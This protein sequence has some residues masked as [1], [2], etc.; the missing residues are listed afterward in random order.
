M[1][2]S[3][4]IP[5]IDIPIGSWNCCPTLVDSVKSVLA[6]GHENV[7]V[8]IGC[9]G[10]ADD[11]RLDP[12]LHSDQRIY[13]HYFKRTLSYGNH[14]RHELQKI[15]TGDL[16]VFLD[17]DD[18]LAEGS[19]KMVAE[20]G[21]DFPGRVLVYSSMV[22]GAYMKPMSW[23]ENQSILEWV[24]YDEYGMLINDE[25]LDRRRPENTPRV[26]S[27]VCH[28]RT[29]EW[30]DTLQRHADVLWIDSVLMKAKSSEK[31]PIYSPAVLG[32]A[33]PLH[34]DVHPWWMGHPASEKALKITVIL[35]VVDVPIGS[36][37]PCHWLKNCIQ[38]VLDGGHEDFELLVGCDGH[39]DAIDDVVRGF[40]D[41][42]IVYVPFERTRSWGNHQ[43]HRL[44]KEWAR[45]NYVMWMNHD[46]NYAPNALAMAHEAAE[47]F[48]GRPLFFRARIA[49]N[50]LIW[51]EMRRPSATSSHVEV[52]V[53]ATVTP[54]VEFTPPYPPTHERTSKADLAWVTSVYDVFTERGLPPVWKKEVLVHVRPWAPMEPI[55]GRA[56]NRITAESV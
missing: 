52:H 9:D 56:D 23:S 43:C 31:A 17:H 19:L 45:G 51:S 28:P 50:A 36:G 2:I 54:R 25:R 8:L 20:D 5:T 7:E 4:I 38:S 10:S 39:I 42:R 3:V 16:C 46:D 18:G 30:P 14:Q 13:A 12:W 55:Y 24:W 44:L 47:D 15:A 48:P 37:R 21:E 32:V 26:M 35:P 49:C 6:G 22:D 33:R 34:G 40:E 29:S 27:V 41:K 53:L 1:K 11:V